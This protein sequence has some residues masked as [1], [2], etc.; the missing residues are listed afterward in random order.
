[1]ELTIEDIIEI[2][3]E[4]IRTLPKELRPP[5]FCRR[6]TSPNYPI[7]GFCDGHGATS[8]PR[9]ECKWCIDNK[10]L[11]PNLH[12]Y[13]KRCTKK[14][15]EFER[16]KTRKKETQKKESIEDTLVWS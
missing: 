9:A 10:E 6:K 11:F 1:M 2:K 12:E 15:K 14:W 13:N 5:S 8:T 16:T 3:K 7:W 4:E